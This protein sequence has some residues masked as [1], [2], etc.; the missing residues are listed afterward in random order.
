[1]ALELTASLNAMN[2]ISTLENINKMVL[3]IN[4]SFS[5]DKSQPFAKQVKEA[6][7]LAKELE[8]VN[9]VAS[10]T[11][12]ATKYYE[13]F[14]RCLGTVGNS[15]ESFNKNINNVE[16]YKLFQNCIG[17]MNSSLSSF[18]KSIKSSE[19]A[20]KNSFSKIAKETSSAGDSIKKNVEAFKSVDNAA[21]KSKT[22]IQSYSK[23]L[24]KLKSEMR[25]FDFSK[26]FGKNLRNQ[27]EQLKY[28][29]KYGRLANQPLDYYGTD[30]NGKNRYEDV[31]IENNKML[32]LKRQR[33]LMKETLEATKND[34]AK[35]V[36]DM[37][38]LS[39]E[40]Q[41][42]MVLKQVNNVPLNNIIS[43]TTSPQ[44]IQ[45]QNHLRGV[46]QE[47]A[48]M[49]PEF[50]KTQ[51]SAYRYSKQME[52]IKQNTSEVV[53]RT[54]TLYGVIKRLAQSNSQLS[55][56]VTI[57][58][59]HKFA[60]QYT[61]MYRKIF[62]PM[63][64]LPSG[65]ALRIDQM[66]DNNTFSTLHTQI[67]QIVKDFNKGKI[68][69]ME[70]GNAMTKAFSINDMNNLSKFSKQIKMVRAEFTEM[71]KLLKATGM[72]GINY[73]RFKDLSN[74]PLGAKN[75]TAYRSLGIDD[76][77]YAKMDRYIEYTRKVNNQFRNGQITAERYNSKMR[78]V[79]H[80]LKT[81]SN[82]DYIKLVSAIDTVDRKMKSS[83]TTAERMQKSFLQLSR[84]IGAFNNVGYNK[85]GRTVGDNYLK[86]QMN[87]YLQDLKK[88]KM[89][90][91]EY[92]K[93]MTDL[94]NSLNKSQK[95]KVNNEMEAQ[96]FA[97][98]K[99]YQRYAKLLESDANKISDAQK[100]MQRAMSQRTNGA[101]NSFGYQGFISQQNNLRKSIAKYSE[102]A[103]KQQTVSYQVAK[104]LDQIGNSSKRTTS[105]VNK[106]DKASNMIRRTLSSWVV[107]MVG[108]PLIMDTLDSAI[109]SMDA[110]TQIRKLGGE[111]NWG[112][113]QTES[114]INTM[115]QMQT[116]YTKIDMSQTAKSV[117]EMS[118]LYNLNNS[119]AKKM[120]E[121]SAVFTSA[122]AREGRST[123]DANLALKDY[124]DGGAGWTRRMQEIGASRENL[125]K[126]LAQNP[127]KYK[128]ITDI[129]NADTMTKIQVLD[130][131]MK[132]KNM[133]IMAQKV[134]TLDEAMSSLKLTMGSLIGE[135]LEGISPIIIGLANQLP[136]LMVA[137]RGFNTWLKG[138]GLGQAI[139]KFGAMST[140][141]VLLILKFKQLG[142]AA[143]IISNLK[144][145]L[146]FLFTNPFGLMIMGLTAVAVL[147]YEVGKAFG[148]WDSVGG[149][150][151]SI[152]NSLGTL[153]GQLLAVGATI[154]G[155]LA[156][157]KISSFLGK[158]I[159]GN[160]LLKGFGAIKAKII[161]YIGMLKIKNKAEDSASK[162]SEKT[163]NGIGVGGKGKGGKT[164]QMEKGKGEVSRFNK[165]LTSYGITFGETATASSI[166]SSSC[167]M[168]TQM[169][170]FA[171]PIIT[172]FVVVVGIIVAEVVL[173]VKGIQLLINAMK[174]DSID[175]RPA[176]EGIKQIGQALWEMN[177][178]FL[179][180]NIISLQ[181]VLFSG[182]RAL[183]E[184][185]GGISAVV[186][187]LKA[188]ISKLNE[189]S[190]AEKIKPDVV[191]KLSELSKGLVAMNNASKNLGDIGSQEGWKKF[192]EWLKV[193]M[194][195]SEA[196]AEVHGNLRDAIPKINSFDDLPAV[197]DQAVQKITKSSE[198]ITKLDSAMK[199]LEGLGKHTGGNVKFTQ[200]GNAMPQVETIDYYAGVIDSVKDTMWRVA[201]K[202]AELK[203][204]PAIPE[205]TGNKIQRVTWTLNDVVQSFNALAKIPPANDG[206]IVGILGGWN[207]KISSAR[208]VIWK[209]AEKL[210]TLHDMPAIP[211]GTGGKIQRVT[212]VLNDV[213]V[214]M[215]TLARVLSNVNFDG[216]Y[217]SY[218]DSV[219]IMCKAIRG[220][221]IELN[222]LSTIA[223]IPETVGVK[224]QRIGWVLNDLKSAVNTVKT[225]NG[226]QFTGGE[227]VRIQTACRLIRNVS[228]NLGQLQTIANVPPIVAQK[229]GF[230]NTAI[231]SL[232]N[233]VNAIR[234]CY[235]TMTAQPI[236][237][238]F[239]QSKLNQIEECIRKVITFAN[240][241]GGSLNGQD[242]QGGMA[243]ITNTV[244]TL[245]SQLNQIVGE[246]NGLSGQMN[247][248]GYNIGNSFK[249]GVSN[250][251][252]GTSAVVWAQISSMNS[253]MDSARGKSD[254]LGGA[255][256][257][258]RGTVYTLTQGIN[259]LK[260]A[261]NNLPS[262]KQIT[263]D[264][265]ANQKTNGAGLPAGISMDSIST[266]WGTVTGYSGGHASTG[267]RGLFAGINTMDIFRGAVSNMISGT[268]YDFYYG[269]KGNS[270]SD[271]SFNCV[272]GSLMVVSLASQLGLDSELRTTNANGTPHMYPVVNGEIF[273]TT[274]K[275]LFGKWRAGNVR[276]A[277]LSSEANKTANDNLVTYNN[278]IEIN[279]NGATGDKKQIAKE[280]ERKLKELF[281]NSKG[282]GI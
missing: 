73:N 74:A 175:L 199:G 269:S 189:F 234:W 23:V 40:N 89:S 229:L 223:N 43:K 181:Q 6:S 50:R 102:E 3:K 18:N 45:M 249:S 152:I 113:A 207:D 7:K 83:A 205:G 128:G 9:N 66:V 17:I 280:V 209:V 239:F 255:F 125:N 250:G 145:A 248:A 96:L 2:V 195:D 58:D 139:V 142:M 252:A 266:S 244:R 150:L 92:K 276:Y 180:M 68:S 169:L 81:L 220:V 127:S 19:T 243:N 214:A 236:D 36:K 114:Y 165:L 179:A 21:N 274:A 230:V 197:S 162:N 198:A 200:G 281:N 119:E 163:N 85:S 265:T 208:D 263:I 151:S 97:Q 37:N 140:A 62:Q 41:K 221:S 154:L 225:V 15:V 273:D 46:N 136:K 155:V 188:S 82:E 28:T 53:S 135:V 33:L 246:L 95:I 131:F 86:T 271:K 211:E 204:M 268:S 130:D 247:S 153:K 64:S 42:N 38:K 242:G 132:S 194:P 106:L 235:N 222:Q 186:D 174:F 108:Y 201:D 275:Q 14:S 32:A 112:Q 63:R 109:N 134:Y 171:I 224:L 47:I 279:I 258:L 10:K 60:K 103:K 183:S 44:F 11:K 202:L 253:A 173:L 78:A 55:K 184:L 245:V 161:E 187:D 267:G 270:A 149:M 241:F 282:T 218:I 177:N 259:N 57:I 137:V 193:K 116:K 157:V 88:M 77:T 115:R 80:T 30:I 167:A 192:W 72:S 219:Q 277:G 22:A 110:S 176:T 124:L 59:P 79:E 146:S 1:M 90:T 27:T 138:N 156:Y 16:P 29:F 118:R 91:Q 170:A 257:N 12:N 100:K 48:K 49:S 256:S 144:F 51:E 84:G 5:G 120:I 99:I 129:N 25:G 216:D 101:I 272:D 61:D 70:M 147:V 133:D 254:Q 251:I 215:D 160:G 35:Y 264:I 26:S 93:A 54:E 182:F 67:G 240:N 4:K 158:G 20:T 65:M 69:A 168:A 190:T 94:A 107:T 178:A 164:T 123:Q 34:Y 261:I 111:M 75:K 213:K 56:G 121:T 159:F 237:P 52:Y 262:S 143:K 210:R 228:V 105:R 226:M 98:E 217:Q 8:R 231:H 71:N 212:W 141:I 126:I 232:T 172:A 238:N 203:D 87:K 278:K 13:D 260:D 206:D 31:V 191:N 104:G 148:W 76:S 24:S 227:Y 196:L 233:V 166:F 185:M 39:K 117:A 122:M